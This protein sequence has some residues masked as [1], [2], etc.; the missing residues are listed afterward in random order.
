MRGSLGPYSCQHMHPLHTEQFTV[1]DILLYCWLIH[2]IWIADTS[3][4]LFVFEWIVLV[5]LYD[6][7]RLYNLYCIIIYKVL[8][9]NENWSKHV[10][11]AISIVLQQHYNNYSFPNPLLPK[12]SWFCIYF[13]MPSIILWSGVSLL[14]VK[15]YY[16]SNAINLLTFFFFHLSLPIT[17]ITL[18]FYLKY[19]KS[20][21]LTSSCRSDFLVLNVPDDLCPCLRM[22]DVSACNLS[23]AHQ[24]DNICKSV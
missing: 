8:C 5:L 24:W 18:I 13:K 7:S 14:F 10:A 21:S 3:F 1:Y 17:A 20:L 12:V 2:Y 23:P 15:F 4:L 11:R 22:R 9:K 16:F 6:F 19:I